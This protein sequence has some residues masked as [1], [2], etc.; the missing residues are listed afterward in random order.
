[1]IIHAIKTHSHFDAI[2]ILCRFRDK[3]AHPD[4]YGKAVSPIMEIS[5]RPT[6]KHFLQACFDE[7]RRIKSG[8]GQPHSKTLSRQSVRGTCAS[9]WS[10]VAL[11]R[12]GSIN[13]AR[14]RCEKLRIG[15]SGFVAFPSA[16]QQESLTS[17]CL[18]LEGGAGY[19]FSSALIF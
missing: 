13:P 18:K 12:F 3:F 10:A 6:L 11:Y 7:Q 17:G 16:L 8:R 4:L 19:D 2:G 14:F 1:L 9:F 5:H 15:E